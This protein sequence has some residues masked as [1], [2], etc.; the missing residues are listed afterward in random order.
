[1]LKGLDQKVYG[2]V[3]RLYAPLSQMLGLRCKGGT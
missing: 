1:V 2:Q 3:Q